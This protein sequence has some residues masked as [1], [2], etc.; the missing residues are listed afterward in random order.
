VCRRYPCSDSQAAA[1]RPLE[2]VQSIQQLQGCPMGAVQ[3]MPVSYDEAG[4][5]PGPADAS[6]LGP[7]P[8]V[9]L[10]R[11]VGDRVVRLTA[12]LAHIIPFGRASKQHRPSTPCAPK[13]R[14]A[15]GQVDPYRATPLRS[16]GCPH[17]AG[18]G[19]FQ[20]RIAL[21][22]HTGPMRRLCAPAICSDSGLT[23]T[24]NVTLTRGGVGRTSP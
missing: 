17:G 8:A 15:L 13:R 20:R 22:G 4:Q 18:R 12:R 10:S 3:S 9:A 2:S 14:S 1:D 21:L 7:R 23:V 19:R 11:R 5:M 6:G 16:E 24:P